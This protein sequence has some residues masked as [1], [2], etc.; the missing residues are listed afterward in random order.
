[1]NRERALT[2]AGGFVA[3]VMVGLLSYTTLN[4][5]T[6]GHPHSHDEE[7]DKAAVEREFRGLVMDQEAYRERQRTR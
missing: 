6:L 4:G 7:V 2:I 1:M 3:V 5:R